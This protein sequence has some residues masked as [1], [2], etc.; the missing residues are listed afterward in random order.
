MAPYDPIIAESEVSPERENVQVENSEKGENLFKVK[1]SL[2]IYSAIILL[3]FI[4]FMGFAGWRAIGHEIPGGNRVLGT[5]SLRV[6]QFYSGLIL[7]AILAPAGIMVRRMSNDISILHPFAIASKKSVKIGHLDRMMDP[8]VLA[9]LTTFRYSTWHGIVQSVLMLAGALLVPIG[10][11]IVTTSQY[12]H[13]TAGQAV[14][15]IPNLGSITP[16]LLD[17]Y[18]NEA[19]NWGSFM[20]LLTPLLALQFSSNVIDTYAQLPA[21]PSVIGPVA[22]ANITYQAGFTYGGIVAYEWA[23]NCAPTMDIRYSVNESQYEWDVTFTWP[24]GTSNT[25]D[26]W[27][28]QLWLWTDSEK[29]A[30]GIPGNGSTYF[31]SACTLSEVMAFPEDQSHL[32]IING[33]FLSMV[34]CTPTFDW[35]V[36]SCTYNG[37]VMVDCQETP[38]A[39]TTV[40]D[41]DGL[42][43]LASWM[44]ATVWSAYNSQVV[45]FG[46]SLLSSTLMTWPEATD[47]H[48]YRAPS[49]A[50]HANIF[51]SVANSIAT[52]ATTGYFGT[53][54]VPTFGGTPQTVY[55]VRLYILGLVLILFFL[56]GLLSIAEILWHKIN[57]MP[58][59]RA[60][61]LTIANA[62]RG[63]W[64]DEEL[65]GGCANTEGEL[66]NTHMTSVMFGVDI[67]FEAH[68]GLAPIVEEINFD[69]SYK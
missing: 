25:S 58:L 3:Y 53:A 60:T 21:V 18:T 5:G 64:W 46:N 59:R 52:V 15:G 47:N 28:T 61:L 49:L 37:T 44:T 43:G 39:N 23:A 35:F 19:G 11:L 31:A 51:G 7:S 65:Y 6:D 17:I 56:V 48:Q 26:V 24:D 20:D 50:D 63:R 67:G 1:K 10:T 29:S 36:G 54:T 42:D 45:V 2:F 33:T 41:N 14:A 40:L 57:R 22:S 12:T 27:D 68:I 66:R 32:V 69:R 13:Q 30:D 62:V 4:T 16:M 34:K 38:G 8:G 9:S 55:A